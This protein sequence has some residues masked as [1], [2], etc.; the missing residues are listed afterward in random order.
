M[1]AADREEEASQEETVEVTEIDGMKVVTKKTA[2]YQK[3]QQKKNKKKKEK[4]D[5]GSDGKVSL[6]MGIL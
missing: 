3:P 5:K 4:S 6:T 1:A 2:N